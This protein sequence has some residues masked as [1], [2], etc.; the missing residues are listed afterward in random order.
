MIQ[1]K[2]DPII[3]FNP[4]AHKACRLNQIDYFNSHFNALANFT[5]NHRYLVFQ[6]DS[7]A[8]CSCRGINELFSSSIKSL[9]PVC[10]NCVLQSLKSLEFLYL[11]LTRQNQQCPTRYAH[12]CC[13]NLQ[14]KVISCWI[15]KYILNTFMRVWTQKIF[16]GAAYFKMATS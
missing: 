3:I 16:I 12:F 5:I 13:K 2:N 7:K 11:F 15:S 9:I 4:N 10:F 14:A 6:S 1:I 8:T